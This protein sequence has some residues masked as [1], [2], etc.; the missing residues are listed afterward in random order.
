M[1][2]DNIA[3]RILLY[4]SHPLD[5]VNDDLTYRKI[6]KYPTHVLY[7]FSTRC[8]NEFQKV[9]WN[10]RWEWKRRWRD[11]KQVVMRRKKSMLGCVCT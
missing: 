10:K 2:P 7:S 9:Q 5:V 11:G 1:F 8:F 3:N 4:V 6:M